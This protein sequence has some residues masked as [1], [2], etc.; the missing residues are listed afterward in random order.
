MTKRNIFAA[1]GI[2]ATLLMGSISGA[3]PA[4][5]AEAAADVPHIAC[6]TWKS[7]SGKK[8]YSHCRGTATANAYRTLATCLRGDGNGTFAKRSGWEGVGRPEV[9]TA[10]CGAKVVA[11]QVEFKNNERPY[12]KC[13]V[14]KTSSKA[15]SAN[16]QNIR[17][18]KVRA[19]VT[20]KKGS[21]TWTKRGPW[22][23]STNSVAKC[24]GG[25]KLKGAVELEISKRGV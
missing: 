5:A 6:K 14:R 2:A 23:K 19:R 3:A 7:G 18:R 11:L 21:D 20:C 4:Q 25:G 8:A 22:K 10:N 16:C 17:D 15:A 12:P 9:G 13:S 1:T 24:G